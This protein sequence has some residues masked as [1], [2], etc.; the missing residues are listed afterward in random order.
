LIAAEATIPGDQIAV[1]IATEEDFTA[2]EVLRSSGARTFSKF[3]V[4]A[5]D[6]PRL[7]RGRAGALVGWDGCE[8]RLMCDV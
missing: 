2:N 3:Q 1:S 5:A 8:V 6:V 7:S 4:S